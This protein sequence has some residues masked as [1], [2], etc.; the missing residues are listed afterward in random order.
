MVVISCIGGFLP[1]VVVPVAAVAVPCYT[2]YLN[3][4]VYVGAH[5]GLWSWIVYQGSLRRYH[6]KLGATVTVVT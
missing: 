4:W 5:P 1:T 6:V 3:L 2:V